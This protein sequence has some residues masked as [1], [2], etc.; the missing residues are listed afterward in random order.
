MAVNM[1]A[2]NLAT[3]RPCFSF[4]GTVGTSGLRLSN[5]RNKAGINLPSHARAQ[6]YFICIQPRRRPAS[7]EAPPILGVKINS[8]NDPDSDAVDIAGGKSLTVESGE[9]FSQN[10]TTTCEVLAITLL[11]LDGESLEA[12]EIEVNVEIYECWATGTPECL[13]PADAVCAPGN[14]RLR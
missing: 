5:G 14:G 8:G 13:D 4:S 9:L 7:E 10:L 2:P 12:T 11:G 3:N 6:S 1:C